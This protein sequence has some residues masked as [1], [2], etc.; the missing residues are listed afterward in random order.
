MNGKEQQK[1][2]HSLQ[3][4]PDDLSDDAGRALLQK[5]ETFGS[6]GETEVSRLL[7]RAFEAVSAK[8]YALAQQAADQAIALDDANS[9]A[10]E[11][12]AVAAAGKSD[13]F[14]LRMEEAVNAWITAIKT[15]TAE[16]AESLRE[17]IREQYTALFLSAVRAAANRFAESPDAETLTRILKTLADALRL[18]N[19]LTVQAGVVFSCGP[20]FT[21][22][23]R[24]CTDAAVKGFNAAAAGFGPSHN[25][26]QLWQWEKYTEAG[27]R[28][29]RLLEKAAR[30]CRDPALGKSICDR[31]IAFAESLRDSGSWKY[32][33][34]HAGGD[35]FI[36]DLAFTPD[37]KR[38]RTED[39]KTFR[40]IRGYFEADQV[41][42]LQKDMAAGRAQADALRAKETYWLA[43]SED[44]DSL[45]EE[46]GRL[47]ETVRTT[48]ESLRTLPVS[49]NVSET[50]EELDRL[51]AQLSALGFGK[52]RQKR[53][54][55]QSVEAISERLR[56]QQ[57]EEADQIKKLSWTIKKSNAR[58]AEIRRIFDAP[59]GTQPAPAGTFRF[60]TK[61]GAVPSPKNLCAH[62]AEILPPPYYASGL[63]SKAAQLLPQEFVPFG[64]CW[65]CEIEKKENDVSTR[66]CGARLF[67]FA[68]SKTAAVETAILLAPAAADAAE[69]DWYD[70]AYIGAYTLL[71]LL[72]SVSQ[73][74]AETAILSLRHGNGETVFEREALR[75]F[76]TCSERMLPDGD[77]Q[78][79]DL[80]LFQIRN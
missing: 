13:S 57:A 16:N 39:I 78:L 60:P 23:A 72:S 66:P 47:E 32:D 34:N 46:T 26:M 8:D 50:K 42:R 35:P 11:L 14:S 56:Q 29:L 59:R 19:T 63:R 12:R 61:N 38:I 68:K 44:K 53:A 64:A 58:L 43:H 21:Q 10:W 30:L 45:T 77:E 36:P 6:P 76:F 40:T 37:A 22:A 31:Y 33:T 27:D 49:A 9:R 51:Q 75:C 4:A 17:R 52:H 25:N 70:F 5:K 73:P 20:L 67:F 55:R 62:L 18:L 69:A 15:G 41:S 1:E 3:T 71:S 80:L 2:I 79:S 74:E 24:L 48:Q 54:L 7:S 65:Q 28:C